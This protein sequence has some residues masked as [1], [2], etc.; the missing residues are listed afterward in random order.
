M[1]RSWGKKTNVL[2]RTRIGGEL[3][4]TEGRTIDRER[5]EGE[6]LFPYNLRARTPGREKHQRRMR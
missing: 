3:R 5:F 2:N 6:E 1:F 4:P